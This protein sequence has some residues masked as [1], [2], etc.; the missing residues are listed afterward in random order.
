MSH[1][2]QIYPST[3]LVFQVDY[4]TQSIHNY[5]KKALSIKIDKTLHFFLLEQFSQVLIYFLIEDEVTTT[6]ISLKYKMAE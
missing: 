1:T 2:Q 3:F 6:E 4:S 5:L